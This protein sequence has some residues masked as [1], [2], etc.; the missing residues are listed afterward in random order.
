MSRRWAIVRASWRRRRTG[1]RRRRRLRLSPALQQ[2]GI[3]VQQVDMR[4][5]A[6]QVE[7]FALSV[8]VDQLNAATSLRICRLTV[9][10]LMQQ[11]L[12]PLRRT[13]AT[14]R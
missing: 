6:E 9:R 12:R 4:M 10:P 5:R 2:A 11:M 8:D 14:Q 13:L 7:V 1:V 3:P